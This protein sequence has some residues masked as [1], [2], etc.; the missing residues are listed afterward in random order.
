MCDYSLE[1][2]H[3]RDAVEGERLVTRRF[4]SGSQGFVSPDCPEVAVCLEEGT[5]LVLRSL[6]ERLQKEK[7]V[8][9]EVIVTFSYLNRSQRRWWAFW[10]LDSYYRDGLVFPNGQS[11]A[12]N[13]LPEGL[14]ADVL[15]TVL[16][17]PAPEKEAAENEI[18][19]ER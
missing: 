15:T 7:S 11:I 16:A 14:Q 1:S 2:Y 5:Q 10:S 3:S 9:E 17:A 13:K 8:G 6:P 18:L 4:Q 12:I 19:T